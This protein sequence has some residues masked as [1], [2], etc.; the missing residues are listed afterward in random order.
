MPPDERP[1]IGIDATPAVA[2]GGGIG[3][4]TRE[5]IKAAVAHETAFDYRLF[6]ARIPAARRFPGALPVANH[7]TH[8]AAALD[9]RWLYRLWH[10][11][12]VPLPVQAFTGRIDLFHSPDFVLPPVSRGIPTLLTVH[13]LSF[14]H[15]PQTFTPSLVAYLNRVVPRSVGRATH[16]LA[17]SEATRADLVAIWDVPADN[18][19]VLYGGVDQ[20]FKPVTRGQTLA[21]ARARYQLGAAPYIL[22]VGTLQPRKNYE[23]LIRAFSQVADKFPH[24]LVFAGGRGW[25]DD[26]IEVEINRHALADRIRLLGF[27]ADED[28]PAL[29]S[30]AQ[31]LAFP[32]LYEGFGLPVLEAMACGVPV[33]ASDASSVPE[34]AGDAAMLLPPADEAGWARGLVELLAN[35]DLRVR[36]VAAGFR[37]ARQFT[38]RRA[39]AQLGDVYRSLLARAKP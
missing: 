6:T 15:Y 9:E 11:M 10:R 27:V 30:G 4:Y 18:I 24:Q 34:V 35:P 17:D 29:Y 20:A 22:S 37:R 1:R 33:L 12:G 2:Q 14:V 8:R 39:A 3:R 25:L 13:D 36:L 38:W 16:I 7:V 5:L 28:L 26:A 32:S 31:L 21:A 19:T 23:L